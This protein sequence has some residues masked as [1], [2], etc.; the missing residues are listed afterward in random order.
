LTGHGWVLGINWRFHDASAALVSSAGVVHWLGEEERFTRRRHSWRD[1]PRQSVAAALSSRR[2]QPEDISAVAVG[3]RPWIVHAA[4]GETWPYSL[5]ER[6]AIAQDAL[7]WTSFP[8]GCSVEF[9]D[10]HYA[11]ASAAFYASPFQHATILVVD[12]HGERASISIY[13]GSR[14]Y[15]LE[16]VESYPRPYSLGYFYEAATRHLGFGVLEAGKTMG[17]SSYESR[18][19]DPLYD[20]RAGVPRPVARLNAQCTW[21]QGLG[22]WADWFHGRFGSVTARPWELASNQRAVAIA[23]STQATIENALLYLA[24][25]ARQLT[26][27][28]AICMGGG[29][30]Q[31]CRAVGLIPEPVYVPPFPHD[32]GVAVGA[33]WIMTGAAAHPTGITPFLG[34]EAEVPDQADLSSWDVEDSAA[35]AIA[36]RLERG[37]VGAIYVGRE[38]VGPRALG[39]RSLIALPDAAKKRDRLNQMKGREPWRPVAPAGLADCNGVLWENQ[40]WRARYMAGSGSMTAFG[41]SLL[42]AATHIDGTCR[43]QVVEETPSLLGDVLHCLETRG[44]PPVVLNTSFNDRGEPI[45]HGCGDVVASASRMAVDFLVLDDL[46]LSRSR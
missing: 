25:R 6:D 5:H 1:F 45:V 14:S 32:G 37:Q 40:G 8:A 4:E 22:A 13:K 35:D 2:L 27:E 44:R 20:F 33:A 11:H 7:G 12:G 30:A 46:L 36:D 29:V 3:W 39:N 16:C 38:E 28:Q 24:E 9:F 41:R 19:V 31:N 21:K 15:G 34:N 23:A 26:G 17:L 43:M 10:H 18:P 42:P